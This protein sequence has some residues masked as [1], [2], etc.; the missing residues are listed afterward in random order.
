MK[1][2]DLL[3]LDP[4]FDIAIQASDN[5]SVFT[6]DII[7]KEKHLIFDVDE[8]EIVSLI[9]SAEKG[10]QPYLVLMRV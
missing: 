7:V 4:E 2:K 8:D 10:S 6:S 9:E 5:K 1:I 3:K